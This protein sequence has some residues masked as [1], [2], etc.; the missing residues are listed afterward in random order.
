MMSFA[1]WVKIVEGAQ[2][3]NEV[4]RRLGLGQAELHKAT[5]ALMPAFMMG[6]FANV[7]QL[8]STSS[9]FSSFLN[10]PDIKSAV[11]QQAASVS[12][13][14]E[15][16]LQDVMPALA[17]SIADAMTTMARNGDTPQRSEAPTA[18]NPAGEALGWMISAMFGLNP[19]KEK[20]PEPTP[21]DIGLSA[22]NDWMKAGQ[23]V[24][25]DYLNTLTTLMNSAKT[26]N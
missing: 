4:G 26:K 20:Q 7:G 11:A 6:G 2:A 10:S 9:P 23:T 16:I 14:N 17:S 15:K 5:E 25:A 13:M 3:M 8:T 24:Q 22:L 18:P 12:G 19:G 1:E 21:N